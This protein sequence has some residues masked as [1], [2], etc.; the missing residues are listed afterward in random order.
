MSETPGSGPQPVLPRTV[1]VGDI[2]RTCVALG[3]PEPSPA[4]LPHEIELLPGRSV[5]LRH[6]TTTET[7]FV[8]VCVGDLTEARR[9]IEARFGWA[10]WDPD[11]VG[12]ESDRLVGRLLQANRLVID[13]VRCPIA[14]R[15]GEAPCDSDCSPQRRFT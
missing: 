2:V 11:T 1:E 15:T 9:S 14:M 6:G 3:V 10:C 13:G 4:P 8:Y 5:T 12:P 7:Q